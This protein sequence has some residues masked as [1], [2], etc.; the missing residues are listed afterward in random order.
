[1]RIYHPFIA[2]TKQEMTIDFSLASFVK[3]ISRARTFGFM[4]D[5]EALR[6]NGLARGGSVENAVVMD[7]YRMLNEDGLRYPD[8]FVRHKIL[9]AI[10]DLYQL[11]AQVMGEFVAHK[12]GHGLNNALVRALFEQSDAW[13]FVSF[14]GDSSSQDSLP[15]G[16]FGKQLEPVMP[17]GLASLVVSDAALFALDA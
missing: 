8:E 15:S 5:I 10:G 13:E 16:V 2:S 12:S 9:D 1:M 17:S 4:K 14:N 3:E 6:A 7:E 11:G